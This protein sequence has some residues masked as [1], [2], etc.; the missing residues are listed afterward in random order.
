[1]TRPKQKQQ[2]AP[3]CSE[4][5]LNYTTFKNNKDGRGSKCV[6][7]L[8]KF[9]SAFTKHLVGQKEGT[10]FAP[11]IFE[12]GRKKEHVRARTMVVLDIEKQK[13][14]TKP[15]PPT[16][17]EVKERI[18]SKGL[19]GVGYTTH[20]HDPNEPRYRLILL[21]RSASQ[22]GD[23]NDPIAH[24]RLLRKDALAVQAVAESFGL[25]KFLDV[26]KTLAAS[27][28]YAPR[29]DKDRLQ[30][31]ES[32][33]NDGELLDFTPYLE[34]AEAQVA[35]EEQKAAS[36]AVTSARRAFKAQ[37]TEDGGHH[38]PGLIGRLRG[39]IGPMEDVLRQYGYCEYPSLKRWA[40][41]NSDTLSPGISLLIGKDGV[42]RLYSHHEND[43]L[44]GSKPVFGSKVHDVVDV[45][46][47]NEF[48]VSD[49][50]Y[51]RGLA[52][53]AKRY[54][55]KADRDIN[56]FNVNNEGAPKVA[57]NEWPEVVDFFQIQQCPLFPMETLN[58]SERDYV[59]QTAR[60]LGV[61]TGP[62]AMAML[63]VASSAVDARSKFSPKKLTSWEESK[64]IWVCFIG[65]SAAKKS[66]L[67]NRV[68]RP[69]Q[70][71]Q[72][73]QNR[74]YK[75]DFAAFRQLSKAEQAKQEEPSCSH[76][77]VQDSTVEALA[78]ALSKQDRGT[79][80]FV[81]ELETVF[82]AMTRYKKNGSD[83]AH[84]LTSYQGGSVN[85]MRVAGGYI[86]VDN[87]ALG[88]IGGIQPDVLAK[89][90][91]VEDGLLER[92]IFV[93]LSDAVVGEDIDTSIVDDEFDEKV[94]DILTQSPQTI[95]LAVESADIIN[96]LEKAAL[97]LSA[98][99]KSVGPGFGG[100]AG[101]LV[102]HYARILAPMHALR[103]GG[104]TVSQ[105]TAEDT[106][107]ILMQYA[108]PQAL[109]FFRADNSPIFERERALAEYIL[110]K[111]LI[112]FVASDITTNVREFRMNTGGRQSFDI[113][114]PVAETLIVH[115]WIAA[116]KS[117]RTRG[118][119]IVNPKV[120]EMFSDRARKEQDRR[121]VISEIIRNTAR[122][123]DDQET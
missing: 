54:D 101:K 2:Q 90:R 59:S 95:K 112:R 8:S 64:N 91:G 47:A 53:L 118:G 96:K 32:F 58:P 40:P 51:Q 1:M 92:F 26:G 76:Y 77:I 84:Y 100:W 65:S 10:A 3:E 122:K 86:I 55:P 87:F 117:D 66:P 78:R 116:E 16:L 68:K 99:H 88:I 114:A 104:S 50:C 111:S 113:V 17:S 121:A 107:K 21:L 120:H 61:Q 6:T 9:T 60:S 67:L 44:S 27:I 48:G 14:N 119:W 57:K 39:C 13:D 123:S 103:G 97:D 110:A 81:D 89:Y 23:A 82:Q 56:N 80:L 11:V 102:S 22:A 69:L 72:D 98:S 74:R 34:I 62:V 29:A 49:E 94:A 38:D 33:S 12:G 70:K 63:A 52:E 41:P 83:R 25:T 30:L 31:A 115:G 42:T 20:S 7:P 5:I 105:K 85:I 93:R 106:E 4:A 108:L 19:M 35:S 15:Q 71:V 109:A 36:K 73:A 45:V 28:F 43:L 18:V 37:T 46:I 75:A 24:A 79:T